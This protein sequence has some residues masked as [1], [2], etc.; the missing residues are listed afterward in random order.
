MYEIERNE[1]DSMFIGSIEMKSTLACCLGTGSQV[2]A[3]TR[4]GW[5][6]TIYVQAHSVDVNIDMLINIDILVCISLE[7]SNFRRRVC[8]NE[9]FKFGFI[10]SIISLYLIT[11][12]SFAQPQLL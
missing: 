11:T 6:V 10:T 12:L 4:T 7:L 5:G 3:F 9:S 1:T 2:C 8:N